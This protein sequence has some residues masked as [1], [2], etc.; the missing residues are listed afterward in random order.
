MSRGL[1]FSETMAG[2]WIPAGKAATDAAPFR[3]DIHVRTFKL[4]SPFG[5]TDGVFTGTLTAVGLAS[6]AAITGTM[7]FSPLREHRL[8]YEFTTVGDDGNA[9]RFNGW[10]TIRGARLLRAFTTLP[11]TMY[12]ADNNIVGT[13]LMRFHLHTTPSFVLGFRLGRRR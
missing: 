13:V 7:R 12:D 11:G 9:Y 10:K 3:I 1:E 2:T 4:L 6:G 5:T 8:A